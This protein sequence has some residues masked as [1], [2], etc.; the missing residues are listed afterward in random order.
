MARL[1]VRKDDEASAIVNPKIFLCNKRH[2]A[3]ERP[4]IL[5]PTG[6]RGYVESS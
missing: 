2:N 6:C 4:C 5:E 3:E 1:K